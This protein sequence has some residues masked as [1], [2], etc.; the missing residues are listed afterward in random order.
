MAIR[1][2]SQKLAQQARLLIIVAISCTNPPADLN[3]WDT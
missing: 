3:V 1:Y 2:I